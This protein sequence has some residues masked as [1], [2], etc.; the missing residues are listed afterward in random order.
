[1]PSRLLAFGLAVAG[2]AMA[3][4][5]FLPWSRGDQYH[6]RSIGWNSGPGFVCG[7]A[8]TL[9]LVWEGAW[10]GWNKDAFAGF[11]LAA[12]SGL[13]GVGNLFLMRWSSSFVPSALHLAYG[14]W[15]GLA[16]SIV[17]LIAAWLRLVEHRRLLWWAWM[18]ERTAARP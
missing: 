11:L 14:A 15:I 3:V 5:L 9:L 12:M 17:L 13:L 4:D 7:V 8:A 2:G 10:S 16:L 1:V 18:D 6:G